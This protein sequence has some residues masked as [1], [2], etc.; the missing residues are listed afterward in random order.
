MKWKKL[1]IENNPNY[2]NGICIEFKSCT[3]RN[4]NQPV[5]SSD[6]I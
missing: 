4:K 2:I 6:N 1:D 3:D 5:K